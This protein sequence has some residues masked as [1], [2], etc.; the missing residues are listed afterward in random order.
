MVVDDLQPILAAIRGHPHLARLVEF[1][2]RLLQIKVEPKKG[3]TVESVWELLQ[4]LVY[5]QAVP[6]VMVVQSSHSM[7]VL[8]PGVSKRAVLTWASP[9]ALKRVKETSDFPK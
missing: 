9:T 6:G 1:E 5:G 8:A 7:D 2:E 3:V 4:Q